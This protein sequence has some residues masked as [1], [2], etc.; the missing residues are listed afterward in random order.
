M[1]LFAE[2][3]TERL[4]SLIDTVPDVADVIELPPPDLGDRKSVV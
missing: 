1:P 2:T 3:L 4:V